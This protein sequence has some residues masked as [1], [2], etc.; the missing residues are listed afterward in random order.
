M[1][2]LKQIPE[3]FVVK[4]TSNVLIG[5]KGKYLYFKLIKRERNTL[6]V[7]TKLADKLHLP[8]KQ[9]GFAGNKDKHAVTE[10]V[11]SVLGAS[12][13][14]LL[15]VNLDKVNIEFLGYGSK[16]IC[17]G[18]LE[19]NHFGNGLFFRKAGFYS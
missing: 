17:L 9:F 12:R 11:C 19:G 13:E 7:L 6:E 10:Q 18:D 1:Y 5:D 4:E 15:S 16:P 14:K 8:E 2:T 3:D